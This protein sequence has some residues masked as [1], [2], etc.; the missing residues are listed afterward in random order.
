MVAAALD[1]VKENALLPWNQSEGTSTAESRS[2]DPAAFGARTL[3]QTH[4]EKALTEVTPSS[5]ESLGTLHDLRK[6]NEEFGEGR[7]KSGGRRTK[8][9]LKFG[10]GGKDG[11]DADG[12]VMQESP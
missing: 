7:T 5:S 8:W 6:W 3:H 11:K 1:A 12:R 2:D 4:F 9:G 10:F